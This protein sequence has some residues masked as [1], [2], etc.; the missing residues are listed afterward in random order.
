M[1]LCQCSAP[2]DLLISSH[3]LPTGCCQS[4]HLHLL[5]ARTPTS[6]A[7]VLWETPL[8][9]VA[10]ACITALSKGNKC[11]FQ[12]FLEPTMNTVNLGSSI[13]IGGPI[14]THMAGSFRGSHL[15]FRFLPRAP[16]LC[17]H[18]TGNGCTYLHVPPTAS[19]P[20]GLICHMNGSSPI[21]GDTAIICL[22]PPTDSVPDWPA[23]NIIQTEVIYY[24]RTYYCRNCM[25]INLPTEIC[26]I[27]VLRV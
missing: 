19:V 26:S 17:S 23:V 24:Y 12:N 22:P 18:V 3:K 7:F 25:G 11:R 4:M 14:P 13:G 27:V 8:K 21:L 20:H 5:E 9:I 10:F 16:G 2:A 15:D 6:G 1:V